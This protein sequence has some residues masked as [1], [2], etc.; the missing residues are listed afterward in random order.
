MDF[1]YLFVTGV[2]AVGFIFSLVSTA[3]PST[4]FTGEEQKK[5]AHFAVDKR[6]TIITACRS[7]RDKLVS[8]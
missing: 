3:S 2:R 4:V 5:K 7:V 6:K 8:R 1:G